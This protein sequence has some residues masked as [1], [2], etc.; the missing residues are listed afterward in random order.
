MRGLFT[1]GVID[2]FLEND[3]EFDG[4]IGISA[5]A[6][7]GCNFKSKQHGRPRRYNKTFCKD[8]RYCSLHSLITTGDLYGA[9]FCYREVPLHLDPFDSDTFAANPMEFYVGATD[10]KSGQCVYHL[11]SD[12][13]ENDTQWMRASASMPLVSRVVELDGY[14]LL[15]GGIA[16]SI[17]Y[18]FMEQQGY[19]RNVIVLTQPKGY[20]KGKNK[21]LPLMKIVL[22]NYPLLIE[23][24]ANRHIVYNHQLREIEKREKQGRSFVIRPPESLKIGRVEKDP[25][26]M[27]RVYQIGR[28]EAE[29][30]LDEIRHFLSEAYEVEK[31]DEMKKETIREHIRFFGRVQGVGFR[32]QAMMAADSLGLTGWVRNE[33]DG[34]VTMEIQGSRPEIDAA[35]EMISNSRHIQIEEIK[36]NEIPLDEYESRFSADYW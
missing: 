7:F 12:G 17:P 11:C 18:A 6:V 28:R 21:L 23:T 2:V 19:D 4:A 29:K 26:E 24:M 34:S 36:R 9:D 14:E 20:T 15:D 32:F 8:K 31:E 27:E 22:R 16:D 1:C 30:H 5:G 13:L 10:V 35:L 3:I 33:D 25:Q